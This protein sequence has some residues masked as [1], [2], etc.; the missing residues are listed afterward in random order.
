MNLLIFHNFHSG[1]WVGAGNGED[2][3][4]SPVGNADYDGL[5]IENAQL[6][7]AEDHF[8]TGSHAPKNLYGKPKK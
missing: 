2:L 5:D 6:E 4:N 7:A 1:K 8:S 3:G